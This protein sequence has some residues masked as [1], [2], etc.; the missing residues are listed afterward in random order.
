MSIILCD[1]HVNHHSRLSVRWRYCTASSHILTRARYDLFTPVEI[2]SVI[3]G[4]KDNKAS[5][6][7]NV[8]AEH[9]KQAGAKIHVLLRGLVNIKKI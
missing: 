6:T 8:F 4:L 9:L 7:D 2:K 5:G 1:S 3:E